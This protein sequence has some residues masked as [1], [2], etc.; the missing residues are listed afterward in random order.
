[1]P[2]SSPSITPRVAFDSRNL[3]ASICQDRNTGMLRAVTSDRE[4]V[5]ALEPVR[6]G[7]VDHLLRVVGEVPTRVR[8]TVVDGAEVRRLVE[9]RARVDDVEQLHA[10]D[11]TAHAR[12]L[13]VLRRL[14]KL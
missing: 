14:G 7:D 6:A 11:D 2:G 9:L 8:S 10:V 1:M 4:S 3:R 12:V 13:S 5:L